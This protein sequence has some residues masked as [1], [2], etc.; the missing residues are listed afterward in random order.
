MTRFWRDQQLSTPVVVYPQILDT[1]ELPYPLSMVLGEMVTR[2]RTLSDPFLVRGIRPYQPGDPVKD[3]HWQASARSEDVLLRVHDHT[4]CTR[5]LVVFNAQSHDAQWDDY[6]RPEDAPTVENTIRL[7]ASM[8]LHALRNGLAAGFATNMPQTLRGESTKLLPT[9]GLVSEES[10]LES[11]AGLQ[12]HCSEKFITLLQSLEQY[13]G[14]DILVI[15]TYDSESIRERIA[16]LEA[17]GNQVTF[18]QSEGGSL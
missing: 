9:D 5:L 10:L 6:I 11:F 1:E 18:Y 17:R 3:I 15:S 2:S 13:S 7:A 14:M 8:C 16:A 12:L 4:I